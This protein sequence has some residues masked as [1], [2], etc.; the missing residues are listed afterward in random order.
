MFI[1]FKCVN[2]ACDKYDEMEERS[3]PMSEVDRQCCKECGE[4]LKRVWNTNASIRTS[5]GFKN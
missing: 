3:I 2:K 5:D 1:D 4:P